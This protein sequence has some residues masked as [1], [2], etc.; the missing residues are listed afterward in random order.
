MMDRIGEGKRMKRSFEVEVFIFQESD[1]TYDGRVYGFHKQ[2]PCGQHVASR[3]LVIT[4][5][6][7]APLGQP[8][9]LISEMG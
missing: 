5:G 7:E 9:G 2:S 3:R 1:G 8:K 4:E 6:E